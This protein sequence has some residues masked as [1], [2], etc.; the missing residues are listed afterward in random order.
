MVA[1]K[2]TMCWF[3]CQHL[4]VR[5]RLPRKLY[6]AT[7]ETTTGCVYKPSCILV[8]R[9]RLPVGFRSHM[10]LLT[11]TE[12]IEALAILQYNVCQ[13]VAEYLIMLKT[14]MMC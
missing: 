14:K 3:D 1:I 9:Q 5:L 7:Q 10:N 4:G 13:V 11:A 8:H 12:I 6:L 2:D